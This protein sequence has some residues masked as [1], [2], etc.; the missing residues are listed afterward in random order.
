MKEKR[1]SLLVFLVPIRS[2]MYIVNQFN[3]ELNQNKIGL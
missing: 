3:S 2:E 1:W